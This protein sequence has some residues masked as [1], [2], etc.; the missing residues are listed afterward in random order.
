[1]KKIIEIRPGEGGEDAQIFVDELA[2]AYTRMAKLSNWKIQLLERRA[3]TLGAF[4]VKLKIEGADLWN[5]DKEA[6]GHR[7]Q[8]VPPTERKGRVHTSSITVA[9]LD[10]NIQTDARLLMRKESDFRIEWFSGTGKGGQHRNKHQNSA[11]VIHIPTGLKQERQGRSRDNNLRDAKDAIVKLLN[12]RIAGERYN[13][14]N[15]IRSG[16]V[17]SGMRGDKRRT[18]QFQHDIVKDHE[19]GKN[20]RAKDIMAGKFELIW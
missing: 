9:V 10:E 11:R 19:T 15:S 4:M 7:I 18:Y 14:L 1:M 20:A 16:Q 12:E 6:G 2:E 3:S 13:A 17:G 8:R 5:L